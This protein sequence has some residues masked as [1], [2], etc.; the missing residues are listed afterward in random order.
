VFSTPEE[1]RIVAGSKTL[2]SIPVDSPLMPDQHIIFGGRRWKVT[3]IDS[4]KKVIY[5]EATKGGQPPLFGGQ[6][7]SIHDVVRQEI[8]TIYREETTASP[9]AIAK[10]ILPIPRP[11][12]CLMKGCTVFATIIWLRNVLFSRGSI[13]TF[14]PGLAI[15]P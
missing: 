5:V 10:P 14:F 4:D 8:L 3:D 15:K 1:F 2:G 12:T 13:S 11:E 7:M 6:G 9:L